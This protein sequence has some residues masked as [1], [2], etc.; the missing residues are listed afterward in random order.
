VN[1]NGLADDQSIADQFSDGLSGIGVGD[2]VDFVR[3]KPDLALAA[4][5]DGR[6][7]ALLGAKIDPI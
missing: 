6:S 5:N 2:L 4:A 3:I 7:Q 1:S